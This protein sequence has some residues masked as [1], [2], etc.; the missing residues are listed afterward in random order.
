M[1]MRNKGSRELKARVAPLTSEV[2]RFHSEVSPPLYHFKTGFRHWK[3]DS[4]SSPV[5]Q[6]NTG[7]SSNNRRPASRPNTTS[8]TGRQSGRRASDIIL[9]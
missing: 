1:E 9:L 3:K 6:Y 5:S 4:S 2:S 7:S 8:K